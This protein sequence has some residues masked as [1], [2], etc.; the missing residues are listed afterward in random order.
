[1]KKIIALLALTVAVVL[2]SLQ[3]PETVESFVPQIGTVTLQTISHSD[4]VTASGQVENN[5]RYEVKSSLPLVI[6]EV[7]VA[8]GDTVEAGET[9]LTVDRQHTAKQLMALQGT[10]YAAQLQSSRILSP[11]QSTEDLLKMIPETL[12]ATTGGTVSAV[13]ASGGCQYG[14]RHACPFGGP[15]RQNHR[16]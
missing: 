4:S 11:T 9:V 13:A 1:M 2:V 10:S 3:V 15:R 14:A 5:T 6:D 16:Q 7:L 12:T 8:V